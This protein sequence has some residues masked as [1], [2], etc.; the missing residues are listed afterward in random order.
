MLLYLM[1]LFFI[2]GVSGLFIFYQFIRYSCKLHANKAQPDDTPLSVASVLGLHCLPTS[3][4][5]QLCINGFRKRSLICKQ[6]M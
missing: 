6:L 1:C 4:L 2:L 3:L 5:R